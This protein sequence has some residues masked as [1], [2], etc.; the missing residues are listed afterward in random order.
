MPST[1]NIFVFLEPN[2]SKEIFNS[3]LK[4]FSKYGETTPMASL[5]FTFNK[6]TNEMI[7]AASIM[8][9]IFVLLAVTGVLS[10]NV[11]QS[12]RNRRQFTVYYLLGMNWKKGAK[13]EICRVSILITITMMLSLLLGKSGLLMLEWMT[14]KRAVIFYGLVFLYIVIMFIIVGAGFLVKLIREDLSASLKD[15]QQGE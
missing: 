12:L 2:I 13:I 6:N 4:K 5:V 14:H 9:I 8:F 7:G 3:L 15:L 1:S 11:I 10:N